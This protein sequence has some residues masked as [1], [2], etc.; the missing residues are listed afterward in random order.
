MSEW[1]MRT[2]CP[3]GACIGV[4]GADGTCR[5]CGRA[6]PGWGDERRR[7]LLEANAGA[8]AARDGLDDPDDP[9]AAGAAGDAPSAPDR[10]ADEDGGS[11]QD[12]E[13]CP[14]PSCI[15][16]LGPGRRCKVCGAVDA[17]AN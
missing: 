6:S 14:S 8:E 10:E 2:L 13:L 3:D 5:V 16:V 15:G 12:R 4:I 11:W 7:G 17:L 9:E 1:D